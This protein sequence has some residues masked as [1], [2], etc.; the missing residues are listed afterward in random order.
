MARQMMSERMMGI[1][2]FV[3]VL[4]S[5]G[6]VALLMPN[7]FM[8]AVVVV[9]ALLVIP[10]LYLRRRQSARADVEARRAARRR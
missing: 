6:M 9:A 7:G 2:P 1:A 10:W 4:A 8:Q 3:I 5:A